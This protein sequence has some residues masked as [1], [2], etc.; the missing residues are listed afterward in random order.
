LDFQVLK[1][2]KISEQKISQ[3]LENKVRINP[4]DIFEKIDNLDV[5]II[6][7]FSLYIFYF[8]YFFKMSLPVKEAMRFQKLIQK[9]NI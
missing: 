5:K 3:I 7:E 1:K 4:K 2:Y 9:Q 8:I 6:M